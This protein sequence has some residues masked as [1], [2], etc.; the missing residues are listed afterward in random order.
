MKVSKPSIVSNAL[1]PMVTRRQCLS[2]KR[3]VVTEGE[4]G[5]PGGADSCEEGA[6]D[7]SHL[8]EKLNTILLWSDAWAAPRLLTDSNLRTKAALA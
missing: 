2:A 4:P 3:K 5:A 6:P 7:G 8:A 1:V